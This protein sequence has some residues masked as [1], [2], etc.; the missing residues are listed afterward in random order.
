MA[1]TPVIGINRLRD[2]NLS[3]GH[4]RSGRYDLQTS[5][6]S[7]HKTSSQSRI[8]NTY[9]YHSSHEKSQSSYEDLDPSRKSGSLLPGDILE[10]QILTGS[11]KTQSQSQSQP[12]NPTQQFA[13]GIEPSSRPARPRI[14]FCLWGPH[15][16]D[17]PSSLS[18]NLRT[19]TSSQSNELNREEMVSSQVS[20]LGHSD[21]AAVTE[22]QILLERSTDSPP[23]GRD[24]GQALLD[25]QSAT[26][27]ARRQGFIGNAEMSAEAQEVYSKF[28]SDY[29]NYT[30]DFNHFKELCSKL[31]AIR[32]NGQ[33]QRSFLWDDFVIVHL[34]EYPRHVEERRSQDTQP[35]TYEQYFSDRGSRPLFKKRSLT[36]H[37]IDMV[38]SQFISTALSSA[39]VNVP[40]HGAYTNEP[41]GTNSLMTDLAGQISDHVQPICDVSGAT[42]AEK[43][44]SYTS[45]T[46]P[47][48]RASLVTIKREG[49]ESNY[50]TSTAT[51]LAPVN[52]SAKEPALSSL[53]SN[54]DHETRVEI[55]NTNRTFKRSNSA[56][57]E[58]V[59]ETDTEDSRHETASIELGDDTFV[60]DRQIS[61][62]RDLSE[63]KAEPEDENEDWFRSLRYMR[64]VKPVWSDDPETPFKR[65][66]RADQNVV[67]ER[68]YHRGGANILLDAKGVIRRPI[69]R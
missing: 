18:S 54:M 19:E 20:R 61:E 29:P 43:A 66:A 41:A 11:N 65:W 1:E 6:P 2:S 26:L 24:D 14:D 67:S 28:C 49:S 52:T 30:G 64:P 10:A 31:Q 32:A 15:P 50:F 35:L 62:S 63:N 36:L 8:L 39:S 12:D 46:R 9:P 22:N 7:A 56:G 68:I 58:E 51:Q 37:G 69:H 38:A 5:P 42:Y 4:I 40:G 53:E 55:L 57:M 13:L 21:P 17:E 48:S 33:L 34:L 59:E 3:E 23:V 60:L 44:H 16:P 45:E 47:T 25:T 27:V